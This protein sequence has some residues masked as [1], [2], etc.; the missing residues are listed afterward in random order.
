MI[1][2]DKEVKIW[3]V[4]DRELNELNEKI[5]EITGG[6]GFLFGSVGDGPSHTDFTIGGAPE[7][8]RIVFSHALSSSPAFMMLDV[9][10]SRSSST[11][12]RLCSLLSTCRN[13]NLQIRITDGRSITNGI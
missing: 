1:E 12:R 6:K 10:T 4:A 2:G 13:P 7:F 5:V 11:D 9:V 8:A 3:E